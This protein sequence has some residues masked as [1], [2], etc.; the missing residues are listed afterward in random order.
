MTT[1]RPKA[2]PKAKPKARP[3]AKRNIPKHRPTAKGARESP[4]PHHRVS[5]SQA[6]LR[7]GPRNLAGRRSKRYGS[8]EGES[9]SAESPMETLVLEFSRRAS[10]LA[11]LVDAALE[12]AIS[13]AV[14]S[15]LD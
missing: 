15:F 4:R 1:P 9:D 12:E 11:V 3:A 8:D 10:P 2:K 14:W 7:D 13:H 5:A 6:A